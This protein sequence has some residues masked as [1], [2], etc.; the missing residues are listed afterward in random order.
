MFPQA[1]PVVYLKLFFCVLFFS[2]GIATY[3]SMLYQN[4]RR[5]ELQIPYPWP[6]PM[7]SILSTSAGIA[8]IFT[9]LAILLEMLTC[10][11]VVVL[12]N[13]LAWLTGINILIV[14]FSVMIPVKIYA[15][16]ALGLTEGWEEL[17]FHDERIRQQT[18]ASITGVK[19]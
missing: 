5:K 18:I 7:G 4:A 6:Q 14:I 12:V 16:Q 15:P 8:F 1:I 9:L 10:T 19:I 2:S 13:P 3:I 17:H 11:A